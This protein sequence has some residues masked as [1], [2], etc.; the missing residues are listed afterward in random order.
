MQRKEAGPAFIIGTASGHVRGVH[1]HM[2]EEDASL[3]EYLRQRGHRKRAKRLSIIGKLPER[4]LECLKMALNDGQPSAAAHPNAE[5]STKDGATTQERSHHAI[6]SEAV[7]AA[8]E[9]ARQEAAAAMSE[10]RLQ[11]AEA[12]AAQ[13]AALEAAAEAAIER[14]EER[15]RSMLASVSS[16]LIAHHLPFHSEVDEH[17]P[18]ALV[19]M[20]R[21]VGPCAAQRLGRRDR[22]L[23][24]QC[25]LGWRWQSLHSKRQAVL[26]AQDAL[27][28]MR[29]MYADTEHIERRGFVELITMCR[30]VGEC[31]D[32]LDEMRSR[33]RARAAFDAASPSPY[34]LIS[35][36]H[37]D[38]QHSFSSAASPVATARLL[39]QQHEQIRQQQHQLLQI[40]RQQLEATET[41]PH[42]QLL[43]AASSDVG[44]GE[45]HTTP[46]IPLREVPSP[47]PS[48]T[49]PQRL[50]CRP[51]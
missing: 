24:R 50:R 16:P 29:I 25:V 17:A 4:S 32:E 30:V 31:E 27:C 10:L 26:A 33:L 15:R 5:P 11:A 51:Q 42:E 38:W 39:Q 3:H 22:S 23:L 41:P 35:S 8:V 28:R 18:T 34:A 13:A 7:A 46:T 36:H 20:P 45:V 12:Q 6:V 43:S 47:T 14:A 19:P 1:I 44:R 9:Q 21:T 49:H 48:A 2:E 40:R 37:V